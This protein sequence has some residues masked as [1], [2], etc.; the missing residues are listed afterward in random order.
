MVLTIRVVRWH[1]TT[2]T[3]VPDMKT[4]YHKC[5][6][7]NQCERSILPADL[8]GPPTPPSPLP[9]EAQ[10]SRSP[11]NEVDDETRNTVEGKWRLS[12]SKE[13]TI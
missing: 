4:V 2:L 5:N 10:Q 3:M 8:Q 11:A 12:A 6:I 13:T 9:R 7:P 1:T